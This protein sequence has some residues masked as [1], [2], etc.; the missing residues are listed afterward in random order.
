MLAGLLFA[1]RDA[2]DRPD[3]LVATLPFAGTS[4]I[5]YQARLL[6]AAGASQI[7][8]VVTRL[9]PDLLGAIS[10]IGGRGVAVDAVRGAAEAAEKLHPLSRVLVMADGLVTTET[11]LK[12][13]AG[14][15]PETLLVIADGLA[16][17]SCERIGGRMAWAG[18]ARLGAARL[19]DVAA[20]PCDWDMQSALLRAASQSGAAHLLLP[21]TA[22]A[23]GHGVEYDAGSL[24][25]RSRAVLAGAVADRRGWFDRW[26]VAPVGRVLL[27]ALVGRGVS[28]GA[29][30]G[31]G[32]VLAGL[33]LAAIRAE[34][35]VT[36]LLAML[37]AVIAWTLGG[38]LAALRDE[39]RIARGQGV[40]MLMAPAL[41][42]LLLAERLDDTATLAIAVALLTLAGLGERA[43]VG[44]SRHLSW[45]GSGAY[46]AVVA[47]GAIAGAPALGL[48]AAAIYAAATL[49]AAIE[50]LRRQV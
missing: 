34:W 39:R 19:R 9:T 4:L 43:I 36:G 22:A 18:V 3:R 28:A 11:M 1:I 10:R 20:M 40:A 2:E 8:V 5:E 47:I 35:L 44:R 23:E 30:A 50:M 12:P 17:S 14:D 37:S 16:E 7:V 27:P 45:S 32:L 26:I 38:V 31:G 6:I 21:A 48:A 29:V 13:L 41:A 24:D 33:G 46:L 25:A 49:G 15:G 42:L